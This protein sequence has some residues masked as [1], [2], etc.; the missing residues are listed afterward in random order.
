MWMNTDDRT[1]VAW[2]D[3][4]GEPNS[5][6]FNFYNWLPGSNMRASYAAEQERF[7]EALKGQGCQVHVYDIYVWP[8]VSEAFYTG[9]YLT[10]KTTNY[11]CEHCGVEEGV[12]HKED[13]P[14]RIKRYLEWDDV[15]SYGPSA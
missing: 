15:D 12:L 1:V 3:L 11:D 9:K 8:N 10:C 6:F 5:E 4:K 7:V 14:E 2:Y 13:C